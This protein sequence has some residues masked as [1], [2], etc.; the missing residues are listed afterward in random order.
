MIKKSL[1]KNQILVKKTYVLLQMFVFLVL[2]LVAPSA[3]TEVSAYTCRTGYY[4]ETAGGLADCWHWEGSFAVTN[5]KT[6]SCRENS[7]GCLGGFDC[8]P[9]KTDCIWE[10]NSWFAGCCTK[11]TLFVT[12]LYGLYVEAVSIGYSSSQTGCPCRLQ[13]NSVL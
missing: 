9:S 11:I 6:Y 10:T 7:A 5:R 3:S 4:C 2:L 1:I 13:C 12:S 8:Y